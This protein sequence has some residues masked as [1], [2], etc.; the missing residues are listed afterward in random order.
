MSAERTIDHPPVDPVAVPDPGKAPAPADLPAAPERRPPATSRAVWLVTYAAVV[1][2]IVMRAPQAYEYLLQRVP[3]DLSAGI[4]DPD[5]EALALRTG[6]YL[7]VVLTALVVG[8]YFSLAAVLERKIFTARHPLPGGWSFGLFYLIISM[9]MIPV[10]VL[11][12]VLDIPDP[13]VS[14]LYYLYIV[15]VGL[16]AP[17]AYRGTWKGLP[18]RKIVIL[19]TSSAVLATLT[20]IG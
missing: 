3:P 1:V 14:V 4:A 16:L 6:V 17:W 20:V 12:L 13:R 5:M 2:L 7:A 9:C 15:G 10:H 18:A 19:F 8:I 11:C